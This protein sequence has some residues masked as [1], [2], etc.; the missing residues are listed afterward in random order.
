MRTKVKQIMYVIINTQ[1]KD[2]KYI[3]IHLGY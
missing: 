2:F 1:I 3:G